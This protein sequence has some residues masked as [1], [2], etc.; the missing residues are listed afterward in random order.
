MKKEE[1]LALSLPKWPAF[2][3]TGKN[4]TVDQAKEILIRTGGR[5]FSSNDHN[6]DRELNL[7]FYGY[8]CDSYDL[9]DILRRQSHI[10]DAYEFMETRAKEWGV[11][12]D[13]Y[14]LKNHQ[15]VSAYVGGPHGWCHWDGS[16]GTTSYNIGKW[17]SVEDVYNE[18][19]IIAK[20]FP[21]LELR[22]Q[23]L[24][25]ETCEENVQP[26]VEYIVKNGKVK[27]KK[28]TDFL[29][30][31]T[32]DMIENMKGIFSNNPY[33]ERGCTIDQFKDALAHS[34]AIVNNFK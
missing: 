9:I 23:L 28:P 26:V 22:C 14:Y 16:I 30:R 1:L 31:P 12:S 20:T 7:A 3:V 10:E 25:G 27:I 15:V 19:V 24:S 6:F 8:Y 32:D 34:A 11:L 4:I 33:R 5:T 29:A 21:Y 2:I 17:P 18:W 13:I